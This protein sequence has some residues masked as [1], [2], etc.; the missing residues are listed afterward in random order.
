MS[1]SR[2][3]FLARHGQGA[4]GVGLAWRG[5]RCRLARQQATSACPA[6]CARRPPLDGPSFSLRALRALCRAC[7]HDTPNSPGWAEPVTTWH[8]VVQCAPFPCDVCADI[9]AWY[10]PAPAGRWIPAMTGIDQARM[11]L[12]VLIDHEHLNW[13]ALRLPA[14]GSGP[15]IDKAI[16]LELQHNPRTGTATPMLLPT[17][18]ATTA[19]AALRC[20]NACVLEGEAGIKGGASPILPR[21]WVT[22]T[23]SAGREGK[24]AVL[25]RRR[26]LTLPVPQAGGS[27]SPEVSTGPAGRGG[28]V[29]HRWLILRR[30][31]Q[32]GCWGCFPAGAALRASDP[33]GQPLQPL[34]LGRCLTDPLTCCS[35]G[36]GPPAHPHP[37]S[38]AGL[39]ARGLL[40]GRGPGVL[41]LGLSGQPG[42]RCAAW[43]RAGSGSRAT[44]SSALRRPLLAA[45]RRAVAGRPPSQACWCGS[46]SIR[47]RS[48]MRGLLFGMGA[49][50][51]LLARCSCSTFCGPAGLV[52]GHLCQGA[53]ALVNRVRFI[54]ISQRRERCS[55]C[56]DCYAVCPE[57]PILRLPVHGAGRGL[58]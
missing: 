55:N 54:K 4:C 9:P 12:A 31:C 15:L 37:G 22:T 1:R 36:G 39:G 57:R 5:A 28:G 16:T 14:T 25:A 32:F 8:P 52:P 46:W 19:P 11:G 48:P 2:R 29:P 17:V 18:H 33:Q 13:A 41:L 20:R 44:V 45:G 23:G 24:A 42:H 47:C 7:P 27:M 49:G 53:F 58:P 51:T 6:G 43:L 30:L 34:L 3:Q 38:G 40:A 26:R 56:M 50:S 10:R 21:G 35:R